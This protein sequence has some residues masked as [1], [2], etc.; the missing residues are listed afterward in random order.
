[1]YM[2]LLLIYLLQKIGAMIA[3]GHDL[4]N[5]APVVYVSGEEVRDLYVLYTVFCFKWKFER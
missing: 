3:D 5:P 2:L 4:G 1:M